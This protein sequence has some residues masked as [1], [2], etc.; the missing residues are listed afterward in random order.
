[1]FALRHT[2]IQNGL[3]MTISNIVHEQQLRPRWSK[4]NF[5][6]LIFFHFLSPSPILKFIAVEIS[7]NLAIRLDI[8]S[9][10]K[11]KSLSTNLVYIIMHALVIW[12][13]TNNFAHALQHIKQW[14]VVSDERGRDKTTIILFMCAYYMCAVNVLCD[15]IIITYDRSIPPL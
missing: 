9:A 11:L 6:Y 8:Y 4:A 15:K 14:I 2:L 13:H 7:W 10:M 1:M 5:F 12:L 3:L